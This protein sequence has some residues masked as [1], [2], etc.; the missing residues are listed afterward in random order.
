MNESSA[1]LMTAM[2]ALALPNN[3]DTFF[4]QLAGEESSVKSKER[5][6]ALPS[7][8]DAVLQ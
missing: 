2:M 8:L 1:L 6:V 3:S 5:P 4:T 7:N